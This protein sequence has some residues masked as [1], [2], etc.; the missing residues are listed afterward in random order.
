M[1]GIDL[2]ALAAAVSLLP[3]VPALA[4]KPE[5][6]TAADPKDR[7][8]CKRTQKT[9]TRFQKEI[10]KTAAQWDAL[11]EQHRRDLAETVDR[12]QVEIRRD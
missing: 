7:V 12:P 2:L 11:A 3:A 1:R 5:S 4:L 10:C 6:D 8:I 9:G